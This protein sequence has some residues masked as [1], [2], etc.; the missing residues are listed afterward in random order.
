MTTLEKERILR[1]LA[2]IVLPGGK[3]IVTAGMVTGLTARDGH[4]GFALDIGDEDARAFEPVRAAAEKAVLALSGVA[5]VSVVMTGER[6]SPARAAAAA[7]RQGGMPGVGAIIAVASG[8]GGVG[9]STVAVNLALGLAGLG[10]KVGLLDADI[11]GPSVP[12]LLNLTGKP[13][14]DGKKLHPKLAYGLKAMSIGLLV[15]VDTPM[16]WRG[17]MA[18]S[19]LSQMLKDVAW[20][21]LD[22][23]IVDMPPGTGD[24]ALTMAQQVPLSGAVIVSTPQD[25]ALIDARK[26]LAMFRKVNVPILGVVENMSTFVCPHCGEAT[27]IFGH[28]GA[29]ETAQALGADFLGEIPLHAA[30]RQTSDA[31][32][33]ILAS[34]AASPQARAFLDIATKVAAALDRQQA[35]PA[36]R[37]VMD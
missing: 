26:G 2:Q 5:R 4:V 10:N 6:A 17:P 23:L 1:A 9:K 29:R 27:A 36:P 16:I 15:D 22:I 18:T 30:I 28:G 31:G 24:I 25:I 20:G 3:D 21:A 34:D 12:R 37:I 19:A 35:K 7:P 33:P 13:D 32:T 11:Y 14:S 8:K